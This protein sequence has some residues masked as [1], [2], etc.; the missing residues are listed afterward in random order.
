MRSLDR[1]ERQQLRA[2][3]FSVKGSYANLLAWRNEVAHAGQIPMNATYAEVK[4]AYNS[5]KGVLQCLA[6]AMR[7]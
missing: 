7:R 4:A 2:A 5:A 6:T 3:G 1:L